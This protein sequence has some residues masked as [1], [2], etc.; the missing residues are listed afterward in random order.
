MKTPTSVQLNLCFQLNIFLSF[1]LAV[2]FVF[3]LCLL[4]WLLFYLLS[5]ATWSG[6]QTILWPTYSPSSSGDEPVKLTMKTHPQPHGVTFT[7][8]SIETKLPSVLPER[9]YKQYHSQKC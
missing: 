2:E 3:Y 1:N 9:I 8:E 7:I 4:F 6:V 5:I